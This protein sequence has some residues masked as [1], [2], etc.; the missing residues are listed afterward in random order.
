MFNPE[1]S[2]IVSAKKEN[3]LDIAKR[4]ADEYLE[5]VKQINPDE[6]EDQLSWAEIEKMSEE[7]LIAL[8]EKNWQETENHRKKSKAEN[9]SSCYFD[10][11][12]DEFIDDLRSNNGQIDPELQENVDANFFNNQKIL[13]RLAEIGSEKAVDFAIDFVLENKEAMHLYTEPLTKIIKEKGQK[14]GRTSDKILQLISEN[15]YDSTLTYKLLF[16]AAESIDMKDFRFKLEQ[17]IPSN[18]DTRK[19]ID[20]VLYKITDLIELAQEKDAELSGI[21][22]KDGQ[23]EIPAGLCTELLRKAHQIILKFSEELE[24]NTQASDKKNQKLLADLEKS[25]IDIEIMAA[26][27]IATKKAGAEQNISEIKGVEMET[28]DE[29]ALRE[30]INLSEKLKEMYRANNAHKSEKDLERLLA[31]FENHKKHNPKFYLIYFDKDNR[32]N[33]EKSL[34]N[35]VG[36]MRSSSCITKFEEQPLV[37]LSE[38]ERYLGAM[39]IDPILQ[40]FYF[41]ENFL[42]EIVEKEFSS[43][44]KK[45]IAHVP[46]NGPSHKIVK[47][48]GFETVAEEGDYRDDAG[49]ITAKRIRVELER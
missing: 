46:E 23:K 27:L 19:D 43:G 4:K 3:K 36:F 28:V 39:N 49:K 34:E 45:L 17:L 11:S 15:K 12:K 2:L 25:Q 13:L 47:L 1:K 31:D 35:L 9:F 26:L 38:G 7:D 22:F 29:K 16:L 41:G 30:N 14:G 5:L 44:T 21:I 40:K 6:F 32:D 24:N 33:P 18:D 48:L 20:V 37:E 8:F 42:R 10:P